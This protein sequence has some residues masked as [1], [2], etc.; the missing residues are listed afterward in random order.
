MTESQQLL[1]EYARTGSEPV[2]QNLVARYV[3]LVYSTAIR[4]VHGDAH[5]AED[6]C[7]TVFADLARSAR[8]LSPDVMPGGWLHRHTCFVAAKLMR[9]ERRRQLRERQAFEMNSQ[10]D[11]SAANLALVAP[12]LDDAINQ[13]GAEDRA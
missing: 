7:Q 13:L 9:K 4:L 10:P 6:V 12:I 1:V 5:L 8:R 3:D 2:F 11:H